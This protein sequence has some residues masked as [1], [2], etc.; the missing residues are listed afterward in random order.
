[1]GCHQWKA[2][3]IAVEKKNYAGATKQLFFSFLFGLENSNR[4]THSLKSADNDESYHT[5]TSKTGK[6]VRRYS[7][8][9]HHASRARNVFV[10]FFSLLLMYNIVSECWINCLKKYFLFTPSQ[11]RPN[12]SGFS[13][14]GA[15]CVTSTAN[16]AAVGLV[17]LL[18]LLLLVLHKI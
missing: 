16:A 11:P 2:Y 9:T 1:M 8:H 4:C 5:K 10:L 14:T 12:C 6:T 7:V 13:C 17:L 3:V 15:L 18:L